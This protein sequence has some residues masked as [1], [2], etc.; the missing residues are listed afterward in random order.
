MQNVSNLVIPE[1]EVRTIH[2][3]NSRLLWGKLSYDTKYAGDTIQDGTPTPD[4]PVAIQTVTGTQMVKVCGK[5]LLKIPDGSLISQGLSVKRLDNAITVSGKYTGSNNY[6]SLLNSSGT[7]VNLDRVLPAGTYTISMSQAPAKRL[8]FSLYN[9]SNVRICHEYLDGTYSTFTLNETATG[10]RLFIN[11]LSNNLDV[12]S[13]Y[14]NLQIEAGTAPTA[15]EPYQ[16][17]DYT[18]NLGALEL[19]KLGNYQD[20]IY[21]SG[22]DWYLHKDI[23]REDLDGSSDEQWIRQMSGGDLTTAWFQHTFE[24]PSVATNERLYILSNNFTN[25][26]SINYHT[27]IEGMGT[28]QSNVRFRWQMTT[29]QNLTNWRAWLGTHPTTVYYMMDT[30]IETQITDATLISQL[31]AIH[32][33]LTRYGYNSIVSGNLPLIISKTNL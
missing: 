7:T 25:V 11:G 29:I 13:N 23:N 20:Y 30:P 21:K 27:T 14:I 26:G 17:H 28:L 22:D 31:D 3:K 4:V 16:S 10:I 8:E 6:K 5:N 19:C 24:Y 2:D 32:Q 12:N 15:Y 1:G 9:S 33:F 18:V